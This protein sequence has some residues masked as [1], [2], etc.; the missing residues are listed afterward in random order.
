[1]KQTISGEEKIKVLK[2]TVTV[3]FSSSGYSLAYSADGEDWTV[4]ETATP[5]NEVLVI[6][7]LTPY[8]YIKLS[9]NTDT[10]VSIIL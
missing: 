10:S 1:M 9:G 2:D 6:N 5:A 4:Y 7:G 3:G 8:S